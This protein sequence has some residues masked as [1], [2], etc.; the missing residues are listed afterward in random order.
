MAA[1][2]LNYK[3]SDM[4]SHDSSQH[5]VSVSHFAVHRTLLVFLEE[6][7]GKMCSVCVCSLL[8]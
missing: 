5:G 8:G 1:L 4:V 6:F 3:V 7:N 2:A